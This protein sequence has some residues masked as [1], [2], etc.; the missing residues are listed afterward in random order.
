MI[1]FVSTTVSG[2]RPV[3]PED[4]N[5]AFAE[6]AD[7]AN[8]A[9]LGASLLLHKNATT[10]LIDQA[11]ASLISWD[12]VASTIGGVAS[13]SAAAPTVLTISK[14]GWF[15]LGGGVVWDTVATGNRTIDLLVNNNTRAGVPSVAQ[16]AA[17]GL[18]VIQNLHSAPLLLTAGDTVTLRAT[19]SQSAYALA[20]SATWL[21]ATFVRA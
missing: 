17:S 7:A 18:Y 14:A 19:T 6:K 2:S 4:L 15:V 11:A 21:S 1:N 12:G 9:A 8:V 10:Q 13:W 20:N 5:A 3:A 16:A